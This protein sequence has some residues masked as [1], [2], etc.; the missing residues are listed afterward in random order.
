M[1]KIIGIT[2]GIGSGKTTLSNYLKKIGF[3]VH[4]SDKVVA[5][6]YK[7]PTKNFIFFLN[8]KISKTAVAKGK[9]NKKII[10]KIIF[11]KKEIRR[12]LE[13]YVHNEVR[14][15]REAFIKKNLKTKNKAIFLDIPLLFENKLENQ[16]DLVISVISTKKL[17][18]ERV[19]KNEKFSE[20]TLKK[21]ML[22]QTTDKIRKS[23]S[24][25]IINNNKTKK[26]F[27]FAAEK[28]LM[29]FLKWERL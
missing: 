11:E 16:F 7:Q 20:D 2:G 27:I 5:D 3:K 14:A 6:M 18:T 8:K 22:N 10:T 12:R 15:H 9:I 19:L 26:D 24:H 29:S 21:I 23:R 4:E 13:R 25:I 28:A 1:T 17:R